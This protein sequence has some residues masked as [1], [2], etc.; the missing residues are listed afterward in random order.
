[1][2]GLD[3]PELAWRPGTVADVALGRVGERGQAAG[4]AIAPRVAVARVARIAPCVALARVPRARVRAAVVHAAVRRLQAAISAG[5]HDRQGREQ[6]RQARNADDGHEGNL[7]RGHLALQAAREKAWDGSARQRS[8]ALRAASTAR[9]D[10]YQ[11][12]LAGAARP[13]PLPRLL[14]RGVARHAQGAP[15]FFRAADADE[16]AASTSAPPSSAPSSTLEPA[17]A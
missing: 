12:A 14:R 11:G 8:L 10:R 15:L 3:E 17:A 13:P 9:G 7:R 5:E 6:Q 4:P 2:K 1:R 16:P